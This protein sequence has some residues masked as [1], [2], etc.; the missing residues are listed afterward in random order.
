MEEF[1]ST[2]KNSFIRFIK[3]GLK[4]NM[5][6][7]IDFT[8]SNGSPIFPTSLHYLN[9]NTPNQYEV[10]LQAIS[11]VLL[12]YD[13]DEKIPAFGFGAKT[14]TNGSLDPTSHCFPLSGN[15]QQVEAQG[16]EDFMNMYRRTLS[17]VEL[18]GPAYFGEVFEEALKLAEG[19]KN[20]GS[21][22]YQILLILTDGEIHDI[23]RCINLVK[24]RGCNLPLS[25]IIVGMGEA[26]F[27]GMN[28]LD[29]DIGIFN[30]NRVSCPRDLVQFVPFR[31]VK[32]DGDL[33]AK[34]MLAELPTQIEQ[35]MHLDIKRPLKSGSK[36]AS[37][38]LKKC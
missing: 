13:T 6:A 7:A 18:S 27:E 34:R 21:S 36:E 33:L 32:M 35:Y 23:D 37:F 2:Q 14:H 8:G 10:A 15:P 26:K 17:N 28:R 29:G 11:K 24:E 19:F 4:L 20:K 1:S 16:M 38:A 22:C 9:S 12:S 5:T 31:D 25:I 3:G 30:K